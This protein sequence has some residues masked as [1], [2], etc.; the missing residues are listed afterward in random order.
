MADLTTST[1]SPNMPAFNGGALYV[2]TSSDGSSWDQVFTTSSISFVDHDDIF[3][4]SVSPPAN[5]RYVR[6]W[7]YEEWYDGDTDDSGTAYHY[8]GIMLDAGA[9]QRLVTPDTWTVTVKAT[10]DGFFASGIA[11]ENVP[12]TGRPEMTLNTKMW[13]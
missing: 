2:Q 4:P 1:W 5:H 9:G 6:M 8:S 3:T 10:L 13:G 7:F 11:H 12:V